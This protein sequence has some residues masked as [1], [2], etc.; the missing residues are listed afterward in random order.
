MGYAHTKEE[1]KLI[2]DNRQQELQRLK[3]ERQNDK[4][5]FNSDQFNKLPNITE[6][7]AS[8][9]LPNKIERVQEE[10][11]VIRSFLR[12]GVIAKIVR[13]LNTMHK[14]IKF[15]TTDITEFIFEYKEAITKEI[16]VKRKSAN[17]RILKTKEG[18][19]QELLDLAELAKNLAIKYDA[20]DDHSAAISAIKAASDIF[21]R[22]AKLEGLLDE[23][24]T[25]NINTQMDKM[26]QNISTESSS[27]KD[28]VLSVVKKTQ[29]A[30]TIE[31][32]F[33]VKED[34]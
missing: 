22:N 16:S 4:D 26:V 1:K 34:A 23:S 9:R 25:I 8:L 2:T 28:A 17:R 29:E 19:T 33:E 31:A 18:L 13:D 32:E 24:T 7:I 12:H 15:T 30:D 21:F 20:A 14:D 5:L 11:F 27:F 6:L 3:D 10:D